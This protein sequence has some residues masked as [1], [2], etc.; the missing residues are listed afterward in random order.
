MTEPTLNDQARHLIAQSQDWA[1][2][3]DALPPTDDPATAAAMRA[4]LRERNY[5]DGE[6]DRLGRALDEDN[7]RLNAELLA[8]ADTSVAH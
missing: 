6:L 7:Q 5:L 3:V 4:L 2:R 8:L 1:R